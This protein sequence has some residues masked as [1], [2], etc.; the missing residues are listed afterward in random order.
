MRRLSSIT[1]A[2]LFHDVF[3][4]FGI[5]ADLLPNLGQVRVF[6]YGGI[7]EQQI[8]TTDRC[9]GTIRRIPN[10]RDEIEDAQMDLLTR[11]LCEPRSKS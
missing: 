7:P 1:N 11:R 8:R 3:L 4:T 2:C 5:T 6:T 9:L 10:V